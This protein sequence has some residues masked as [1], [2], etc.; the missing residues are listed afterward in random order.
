[1]TYS[2]KSRAGRINIA[3]SQGA[4]RHA[5]GRRAGAQKEVGVPGQNLRGCQIWARTAP[6]LAAGQA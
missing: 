5:L 3:G 6:G 1:M 4:G 2:R